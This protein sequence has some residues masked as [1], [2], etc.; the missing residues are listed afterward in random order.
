[1][2]ALGRAR[3]TQRNVL[4]NISAPIQLEKGGVYF[5]HVEHKNY[6]NKKLKNSVFFIFW[7]DPVRK[8]YTNL[9]IPL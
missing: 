8:K 2:R 7:S 4:T 3:T 1:M 6:K 9:I 5:R